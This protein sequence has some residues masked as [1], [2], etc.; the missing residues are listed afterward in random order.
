MVFWINRYRQIKLLGIGFGKA[1]IPIGAPLHRRAAT[2][3][4]AKIKIVA[5]TNF[6]AVVQHRGS[7]QREEENI[8]ELDLAAAVGQQGG[9][10]PSNAKINARGRVVRSEEHTS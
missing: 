1:G 8:Q 10:P 3:A 6:V 7:R 9:Q 4:I 5:H 2:I